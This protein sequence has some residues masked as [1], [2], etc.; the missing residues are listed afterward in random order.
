LKLLLQVVI[1]NKQ[2]LILTLCW[3][4]GEYSS[5]QLD[6]RCTNRVQNDYHEALELFVYER[7]SLVK[8]GLTSVESSIK[9][10]A[11]TT[12]VYLTRLM[13]CII[14][15]LTK[16]ASR[17]QDL[18]SRVLLC[19]AKIMRFHE[20]F[21]ASVLKRANE[22]MQLLKFPSIAAAMLEGQKR[23]ETEFVDVNSAKIREMLRQFI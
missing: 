20:Y 12:D 5:V 19:L 4:I 15:S 22:C 13:L 18:S 7:M 21:H 11:S 14:S 9:A 6:F 8:M 17:S 2:E 1:Q 16:L 23:N 10:A 3:L